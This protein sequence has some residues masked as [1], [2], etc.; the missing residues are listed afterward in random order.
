VNYELNKPAVAGHINIKGADII[1]LPEKLKVINSSM[2]LNFIKNDLVL[3]NI[4]LQ[5]GRSGSR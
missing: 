4:R 3:K 5:S 1:Y 2:S